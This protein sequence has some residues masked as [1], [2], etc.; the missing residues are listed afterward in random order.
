MRGRI[1]RDHEGSIEIEDLHLFFGDEISVDE[2][3][4]YIIQT[5]GELK[6][7]LTETDLECIMNTKMITA[8]KAE[9][10][11]KQQVVGDIEEEDYINATSLF[12]RVVTSKEVKE[13]AGSMPQPDPQPD[14]EEVHRRCLAL[15]G[16][17]KI[18]SQ[19]RIPEKA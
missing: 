5:F 6:T 3:K 10:L 18:S 9:E 7:R 8:N 11:V 1:D 19:H 4:A 13:D 16:V 17:D 12:N 14:P 2:I 15:S